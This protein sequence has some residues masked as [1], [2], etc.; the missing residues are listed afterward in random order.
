VALREREIAELRG[1]DWKGD[2]HVPVDNNPVTVIDGRPYLA[3]DA[4][5]VCIYSDPETKLCRVQTRFGYDAKPLGCRLFPFNP[6]AVLPGVISCGVRFDC[7]AVQQN[8]GSPLTAHREQIVKLSGEMGLADGVEQAALDGLKPDAAARLAESFAE[9]AVGNA[10]TDP[11]VGSVGLLLAARHFRTLGEN[12]LNDRKTMQEILPSLM[13]K[14]RERA[15]AQLEDAKLLG[16]TDRVLFRSWLANFMRRD[17][18]LLD[19]P[20]S[21][22][23]RRMLQFTAIL[24]GRG[25]LHNL[26]VEHPSVPLGDAQLF[27][28]NT[29]EPSSP[30]VWDCWRRFMDGRL[31]ALQFFG[32]TLDGMAFFA[33]AQSLSATFALVSAA[34]KVRAAAAG[35]AGGRLEAAD[36]EYAVG[37]VDHA[38]GRSRLLR[39]LPQRVVAERFCDPARFAAALR[40]LGLP[41]AIARQQRFA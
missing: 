3:H 1:R 15:A 28:R 34:A 35:R 11:A 19:H 5:G 9:L 8:H 37:A 13:T 26:G 14:F 10:Q 22:R 41:A 38:F 4:N 31:R 18:E 30:A 33:G 16:V 20:H 12:F 29:L 32:A 2:P 27:S 6:A 23:V 24:S 39:F 17:E 7:P 36:V 25:N 21:H 40:S